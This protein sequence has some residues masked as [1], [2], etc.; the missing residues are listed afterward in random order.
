MIKVEVYADTAAEVRKQMLE[1]LNL[2]ANQTVSITISPEATTAEAAEQ[3]KAA[4]KPKA[5]IAALPGFEAANAAQA[6]TPAASIQP[7][8]PPWVDPGAVVPEPA[9]A[10]Q[11][12]EMPTPAP[13]TASEVREILSELSDKRGREALSKLLT[14]FNVKQFSK[15]EPTQYA[16]ATAM[17]KE[18]LK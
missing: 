18:M 12:V 8:P 5:K 3:I 2:D 16:A 13:V 4:G 15:L 1:L 14:H 6:R 17:A 11:Q 9:P 7:E 10:G